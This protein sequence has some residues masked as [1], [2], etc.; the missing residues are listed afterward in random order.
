MVQACHDVVTSGPPAMIDLWLVLLQLHKTVLCKGMS[1][2]QVDVQA[3]HDQQTKKT[4][5]CIRLQC[6]AICKTTS[7]VEILPS[8]N[9]VNTIPERQGNH[10]HSLVLDDI[11]IELLDGHCHL[12]TAAIRRVHA[13]LYIKWAV[14]IQ[15]HNKGSCSNTKNAN[16]S[17]PEHVHLGQTCAWNFV[18]PVVHWHCTIN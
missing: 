18:L 3:G 17:R 8:L 11:L 13:P 10:F 12:I 7:N 6:N 14:P 4:R 9:N 2:E 15:K 16:Q 5:G 1:M